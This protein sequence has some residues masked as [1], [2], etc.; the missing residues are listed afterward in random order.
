MP[1]LLLPACISYVSTAF[2]STPAVYLCTW[3]SQRIMRRLQLAPEQELLMLVRR[4]I[5][6]SGLPKTVLA[7]DSHISR[8]AL[9]SWVAGVRTP[10]ANS[11]QHLASGLERRA[12]LLRRL[13]EQVREAAEA[14]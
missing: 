1:P 2:L 8:A 5:Q 3:A 14:A 13:A 4:V 12:D 6:E 7:G 9:N 11:L 10:Q